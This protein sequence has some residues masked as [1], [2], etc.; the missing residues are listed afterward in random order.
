MEQS[1]CRKCDRAIID[2]YAYFQLAHGSDP[3]LDSLVDAWTRTYDQLF[4]VPVI[5]RPQADG[6]RAVD[7]R[8]QHQV[9]ER[10]RADMD[11]RA[12]PYHDLSP[13]P[14]DGWLDTVENLVIEQLKP[15]QLDLL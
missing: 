13:I 7:P 15:P 1:F 8:F 14:R 5:D 9:E 10:V 4:L 12:V 3:M 2:N 11:K 6:L